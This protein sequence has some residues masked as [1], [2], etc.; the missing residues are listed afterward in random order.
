MSN[1]F[2]KGGR[3]KKKKEIHLSIELAFSA[4]ISEE[5][6]SLGTSSCTYEGYIATIVKV[7]FSFAFRNTGPLSSIKRTTYLSQKFSANYLY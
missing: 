3:K 1:L 6:Y 5:L 4:L 7:A 2:R